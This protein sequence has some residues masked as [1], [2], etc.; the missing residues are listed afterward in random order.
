[1]RALLFRPDGTV[2]EINIENTLKAL[3]A[4]VDGHIETI[5]IASDA[6]LVC[7]EEGRLRNLEPQNVFGM[8]FFGNILMVGTKD[9]DFVDLTEGICAKLARRY[10]D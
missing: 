9:D 2:T 10:K 1:M 8:I 6:C 3:R 7:N 5:T 4:V